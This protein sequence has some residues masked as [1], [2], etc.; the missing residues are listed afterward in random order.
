MK[1]IVSSTLLLKQLQAIGG[2][3]NSSNTLPILDNFLFELDKDGLIISASDLETTMTAKVAVTKAEK[4][5]SVAIPAKI[6][7][8]TLKTFSDIPITFTVDTKGTYAIEISAGEGKYKLSGHNAEE[9]PKTP[10]LESASSIELDS[11]IIA[12]AIN[13]SLFATGNDELRPVMSGVFCQLS[14]EN[15]TFV[16]TDAHKLVRYRRADAKSAEVAS[17]ILPKK[18]LNQLKNLLAH[19]ESKV[20]IEYNNTNAF[21]AFGNY[22]LICRLID[23]KYPNYEAVIPTENPNKLTIERI[24][25]LNSIK[26]VS[27]FSNQS[28]HQV[29]FKINGKELTLSAEDLDFAN[30]AKERLTCQYDGEDME[31]GFNSKFILEMLN[32]ID[33]DEVCLEMSAPNRAGL[34][35]PVNSDN[36]NEDLLMLVMPVMLNT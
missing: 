17:F 19:E 27:I 7:L 8:D 4:T 15:I 29:R 34:L 33:T 11:L 10:T 12:D 23:G 24:P 6:L 35:L 9:F 25:F 32:I 22:N 2:V 30:E 14:P 5:G 20:K 26:R 18:P 28:T 13:K 16:A 3:I 21:F 36:K 1:F 31:I